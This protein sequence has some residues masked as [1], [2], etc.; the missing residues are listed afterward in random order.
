[1]RWKG[2]KKK[3]KGSSELDGRGVG[4]AEPPG[5]G[6]HV[7]GS[8][9][10]AIAELDPEGEALPVEVGERLPVGTPVPGHHQPAGSGSLDPHARH[11]SGSGH[12]RHQHQLEVVPAVDGK[13]YP[14]GPFAAYP[15]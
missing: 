13:P 1:M 2:R 12:V 3:G 11:I 5:G 4:L 6:R 15:E 10:L 7:V 14:T 9:D 8:P